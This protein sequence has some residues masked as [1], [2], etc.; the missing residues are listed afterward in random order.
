MS[1]AEVVTVVRLWLV[2]AFMTSLPDMLLG[3][4]SEMDDPRLNN[5]CLNRPS[6]SRPMVPDW[7]IRALRIEWTELSFA[8]VSGSSSS[9]TLNACS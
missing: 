7:S 3:L 9:G 4:A 5:R 8:D 6:Q 1:V 2:L